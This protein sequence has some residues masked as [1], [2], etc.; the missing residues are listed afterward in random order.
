METESLA[1]SDGGKVASNH[2][3]DIE[4]LDTMMPVISNRLLNG[5]C[6]TAEYLMFRHFS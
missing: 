5:Q 4:H 6:Y 2:N 1:T 3:Y